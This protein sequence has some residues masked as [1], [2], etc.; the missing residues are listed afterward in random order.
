M[1]RP[2]TTPH[3]HLTAAPA[4]AVRV[5][6]PGKV[7]LSLRVGPA[8]AD[9]YHPLVTVFQ[10]VS[11]FEEVTATQVA[12][13]AGVSISVDGPQAEAVPLDSS[14]LAWRAAALLAQHVGIEPDVALH[15][16]EFTH[17]ASDALIGKPTSQ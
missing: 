16:A 6:A 13:G 2:G 1:N 3:A 10:A 9:G 4:P 15:I 7:N 8:E 14:N 17:R 5:R 12:P 11:L